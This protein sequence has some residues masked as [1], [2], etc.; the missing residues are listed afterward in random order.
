MS[1]ASAPVFGNLL[2]QSIAQEMTGNDNLKIDFQYKIYKQSLETISKKD[3]A[4]GVILV[5]IG[6]IIVFYLEMIFFFLID[7]DYTQGFYRSILMRGATRSSFIL[8]RMIVDF[9][10]NLFIF[11][12]IVVVQ[13]MFG[14]DTE[15]WQTL[16]FLFC[17]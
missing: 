13:V 6:A 16:G 12:V 7:V 17:R 9:L 3:I 2:L 14:I 5:N 10:I 11:E 4:Y 1:P 8:T 15:G